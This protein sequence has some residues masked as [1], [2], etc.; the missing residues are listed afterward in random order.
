[1]FLGAPVLDR[2]ALD[3]FTGT[4]DYIIFRHR[5]ACKVLQA[6]ETCQQ[7][8][9]LLKYVSWKYAH[10]DSRWAGST[11]NWN[12]RQYCGARQLH[13]RSAIRTNVLAVTPPAVAALLINIEPARFYPALYRGLRHRS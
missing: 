5:E 1:M 7:L 12:R 13:I 4:K 6:S 10:P 11:P 8:A 3:S 2:Q 9:R